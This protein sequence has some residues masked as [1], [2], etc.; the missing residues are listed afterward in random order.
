MCCCCTLEKASCTSREDNA[1]GYF[2]EEINEHR[3]L[4]R[5]TEKEKDVMVWLLCNA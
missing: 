5:E 4:L 2:M 3:K 1:I